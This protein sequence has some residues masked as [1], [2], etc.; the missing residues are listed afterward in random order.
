MSMS[1]RYRGYVDYQDILHVTAALSLPLDTFENLIGSSTYGY[2]SLLPITR[3]L[4]DS[5]SEPSRHLHNTSASSALIDKN[6][7]KLGWHLPSLPIIH[8]PI[9]PINTAPTAAYMAGTLAPFIL[10]MTM[11]SPL[12]PPKNGWTE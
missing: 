10:I 3:K 5:V 1:P 2:T 4:I 6:V 7:G 9:L 11:N 12:P 8:Q